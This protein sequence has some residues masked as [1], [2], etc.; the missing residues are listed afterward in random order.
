MN[1]VERINELF[2]LLKELEWSGHK[3]AGEVSVCPCC[4]GE[5]PFNEELSIDCG[6]DLE[7]KLARIIKSQNYANISVHIGQI[8][9][10]ND[11]IVVKKPI[12]IKVKYDH[13][14]GGEV[15]ALWNEVECRGRGDTKEEA[16]SILKDDIVDLFDDLNDC[17]KEELGVLPKRWLKILSNHLKCK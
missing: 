5:S 4:E 14:Y 8:D 17:K 16:I 12:I 6:H 7:C 15:E 1:D 2:D 11:Y 3:W 13:A 9:K 10:L